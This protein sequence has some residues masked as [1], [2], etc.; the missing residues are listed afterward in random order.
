MATVVQQ[1]TAIA[2]FTVASI[3][4]MSGNKVAIQHLPHPLTLILLQTFATLALLM[5]KKSEIAP[6]EMKKVILWL[7]CT[8][9]FVFMLATSLF[10]LKA[11]TISAVLIFRN[12]GNV[13]NAFVESVV[14]GKPVTPLTL[15][16][17]LTTVFGAMMYGYTNADIT[18]SGFF[19][20]MANVL[21]QV[22]YGVYVKWLMERRKAEL[23]LSKFGMAFYNNVLSI[24]IFLF[25]WLVNGEHSEAAGA[26]TTLATNGTGVFVVGLTCVFGFLISIAGFQLQSVVSATAF[27]VINNAAKIA[28]ILFGILIMKDT[29]SGPISV[30]GCIVALG[31][32]AWYS[33]EQFRQGEDEKAFREK[34]L[35]RRPFVD[36]K[37]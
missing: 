11:V 9:L 34:E 23:Q 35:T 8:V 13:I 15:A 31:G 3:C 32:G 24:P 26:L 7:P 6:L 37:S 10:A 22:G 16:A 19:W 17:L 1:V 25:L 36:E 18:L 28:N 2:F 33:Y 20:V 5:T 21:G 4:M 30:L 14:L 27:M 29:F 12:G